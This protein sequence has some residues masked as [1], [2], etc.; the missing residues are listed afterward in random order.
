MHWGDFIVRVLS[1][2]VYL[3]TV[4]IAEGDLAFHLEFQ[5]CSFT[6]GVSTD[7]RSNI[8]SIRP[9]PRSTELGLS[10]RI[11][12]WLTWRGGLPKMSATHKFEFFE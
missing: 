5:M 3:V 4:P 1:V 7:E 11:P 2:V 9:I 6:G 8:R 12:I 10:L